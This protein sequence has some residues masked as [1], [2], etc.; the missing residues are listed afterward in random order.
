MIVR[1]FGSMK[2]RVLLGFVAALVPF[3]AFADFL[4]MSGD[5]VVTIS[6]QPL[7][8]EYAIDFGTVCQGSGM[9]SKT[10]QLQITA[11]SHSDLVT[12][13]NIIFQSGSTATV[14]VASINGTGLG[15]SVA[16]PGTIVLPANWTSL[17]DG[18]LSSSVNSTVTLDTSAV[19]GSVADTVI[20]AA[21]GTNLNNGALTKNS[22]L[23]VK[24]NIVNCAADVTVTKTA[25][26]PSINAGDT[27][28]FSIVVTNLGPST[29][30]NVTLTDTLPSGLTWSLGGPDAAAC[31]ISA[32]TLSC[33]FGSVGFPGSRTVTVSGQTSASNCGQINNT[34]IVSA[35]NDSNPTNNSSS[36]SITVSCKPSAQI[37]PTN[38]TCQQY[39]SGTAATLSGF[40]YGVKNGAINN[41]APGVAFYFVTAHATGS[42]FTVTTTQS[43]NGSTPLFDARQVQVFDAACNTY[44]NF[45]SSITSGQV[46]TTINGATAGQT[47]I[48]L[49][50][51][52][53]HSVVGSATP[54]PSTVTYT[55][56]TAGVPG[57]TQSIALSE[58]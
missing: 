14:S 48:V 33:N 2:A 57:S 26:N 9:L 54:S 36:A 56:T 12:N 58:F 46:S 16:A 43:D 28:S 1:F 31:A 40:G 27:A 6:T 41:V 20:Y 47:F 42:S 11:R 44:S 15:A 45:T 21:S 24:A 23:D 53:P 49:F 32:G 29:A 39:V 30:S 18:T 8:E 19:S 52:D 5:S 10:F 34:A 35:S 38:T 4:S 13:A 7:A 55:Y 25:A 37:T 22:K 17:P 3:T 50:K 51:I